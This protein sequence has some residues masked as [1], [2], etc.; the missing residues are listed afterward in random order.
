MKKIH[1]LLFNAVA[2]VST[3]QIPAGAMGDWPFDNNALD[4][5]GNGSHGIVTGATPAH[6]RFGNPNKAYK[7]N[8]TANI[9]VLHNAFVDAGSGNFTF[10]I[11][12]KSYAN[13]SA[14]AIF[15]KHVTGTW[16]G[17]SLIANNTQNSGYCTTPL[18][19]FFYTAC[20][21][22][23]DACSDSDVLRDS[24][25]HFYTGMYQASTLSNYLYVDGVLQADVGGSSGPLS[26]QSDLFFG[27]NPLN[28][29]GFKGVLDGARMYQ[30]L[31]TPAEILQLYNENNFGVGIGSTANSA[32]QVQV[33][34][35]PV[36]D[37]FHVSLS[38]EGGV[39]QL[40]VFNTLGQLVASQQNPEINLANSAPGVYYLKVRQSE[41]QQII[42]LVKE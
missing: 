24:T 35:N 29:G 26:N 14:S 22:L 13:S 12:A 31:L 2:L 32:L 27:N 41:K 18:H 25:W 40:E 9:K 4:M 21:A 33:V 20:A 5:S 42:K 19:V 10:C 11:W 30:R 39:A 3:A 1:L 16:N 8:G 38:G 36:Q 28:S 6:D 34:P 23:Q 7:F 37:V 15:E 17:Y